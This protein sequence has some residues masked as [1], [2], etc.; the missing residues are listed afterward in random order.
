LPSDAP[1]SASR[2][3][4]LGNFVPIRTPPVGQTAAGGAE[5]EEDF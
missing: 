5:T 4:A 2:H 3:P 1:A